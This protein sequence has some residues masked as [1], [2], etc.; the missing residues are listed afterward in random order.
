M[1]K[2]QIEGFEVLDDAAQRA[3]GYVIP[4]WEVDRNPA[5][6]AAFARA[7]RI[8]IEKGVPITEIDIS[9]L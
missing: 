2:P 1:K 8:S 5:S 7:R 4:P 9:D 3:G 6:E